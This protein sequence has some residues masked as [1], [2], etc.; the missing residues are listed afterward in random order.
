MT[1]NKLLTPILL[2]TTI[3]STAA[4]ADNLITGE[5]GKCGS[6]DAQCHY[7]I[8]NGVLTITGNAFISSKPWKNISGYKTGITSVIIEN[9]I[10]GITNNAFDEITSLKSVVIPNSV[11]TINNAAFHYAPSLE[12]V[13]FETGSQLTTLAS[14]AFSYSPSLKSIDLPESLTGTLGSFQGTGLTS[15]V[16]P[17]KVT[18]L[19]NSCFKDATSLESVTLPDSLTYIPQYGFQNTSLKSIDIPKNVTTI[20]GMAFKDISSLENITF[21]SDSKLREINTNAFEN[22]TSLKSI[23]IPAS[24]TQLGGY[25]FKGSGLESITF[26]EGSK[27]T[28]I[29]NYLFWDASNLKSVMLPDSITSVGW[30][31]FSGVPS[32]ATVYCQEG[33]NKHGG[34]SC[35]E[36]FT[37]N[38]SF[39]GTIQ[40]Y[41]KDTNG[42]MILYDKDETTGE[43]TSN[44]KKYASIDH[45][46][47]GRAMHE[48]QQIENSD[49]SVYL[50]DENGNLIG[51]KGKRIYT[52]EE[53][54]RLSKPTGN[55]FKLRYK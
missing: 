6:T 19:D 18:Q 13:T 15:I 21:A 36:L 33:G 47:A 29:P 4:F 55:T 52:V 53:A 9:G 23:N 27:L 54:A 39:T 1:K 20:Q 28:S 11:K 3:L 34:K 51:I 41:A 44:G 26:D 16:I 2:G 31:A 46:I 24:V 38:S 17:S 12:S 43:I 7:E 32:T 37:A 14:N 10:T 30:A 48:I 45:L 42:N 35:S 25:L 40:L 8:T 22:A 49:G 5:S 50:Y